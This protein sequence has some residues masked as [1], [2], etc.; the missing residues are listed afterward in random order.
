MRLFLQS[1]N[2]NSKLSRVSNPGGLF[3]ILKFYGLPRP[4]YI[5]LFINSG[6]RLTVSPFLVRIWIVQ[7]YIVQLYSKFF[8]HFIRPESRGPQ[9]ALGGL[10]TWI[11]CFFFG[12]P[13]PRGERNGPQLQQLPGI[14]P[15]HSTS[16][17]FLF[18]VR[19]GYFST[20]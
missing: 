6:W 3:L 4:S 12:I 2:Y 20:Q 18:S 16:V 5:L 17:N 8:F 10:I 19:S 13:L 9:G 15:G 1:S 14:W 11:K 7:F